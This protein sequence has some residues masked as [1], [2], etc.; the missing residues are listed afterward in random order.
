M[1]SLSANKFSLCCKD[2]KYFSTGTYIEATGTV[3][4]FMYTKRD[5]DGTGEM[6]YSKPKFLIAETGEY[7]VLNTKDVSKG[8]TYTIRYYPNTSRIII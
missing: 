3:I 4:D 2:Y 6:M 1:I 8:K 5:Y 7:I